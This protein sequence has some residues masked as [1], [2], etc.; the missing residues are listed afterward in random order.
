MQ[1]I[2]ECIEPNNETMIIETHIP[3]RAHFMA[4]MALL[5]MGLM[6]STPSVAQLQ[7]PD[8]LTQHLKSDDYAKVYSGSL[9]LKR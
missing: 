3:L 7:L 8:L 5:F 2:K 1:V 4:A 9:S 6:V